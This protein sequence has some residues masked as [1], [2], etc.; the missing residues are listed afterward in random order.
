MKI[1]IG[2]ATALPMIILVKSKVCI[3][4]FFLT[5]AHRTEGVVLETSEGAHSIGN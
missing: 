4:F 5:K 1:I 2:D 3:I